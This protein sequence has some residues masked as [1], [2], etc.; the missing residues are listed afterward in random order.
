MTYAPRVADSAPRVC[1]FLFSVRL[2]EGSTRSDFPQ[3]T[4]ASRPAPS[5]DSTRP[6][7]EE[8]TGRASGYA[9][10]PVQARVVF[11]IAH[12]LRA[13]TRLL[14]ALRRDSPPKIS[15]PRWSAIPQFARL[16]TWRNLTY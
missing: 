13:H 14:T 3:A 4:T 2:I 9:V 5:P 11:L 1:E 16:A 15:E 10:K 6:P 12:V 8:E 7:A